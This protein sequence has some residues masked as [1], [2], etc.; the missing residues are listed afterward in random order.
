MARM[1]AQMSW[2]WRHAR[3]SSGRLRETSE[4]GEE[5]DTAMRWWRC[6]HT[7]G[8]WQMTQK[9][10]SVIIKYVSIRDSHGVGMPLE[11]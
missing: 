8:G 10:E 1:V 2:R 7:V 9:K 4:R 6:C 5:E 3:A 11:F